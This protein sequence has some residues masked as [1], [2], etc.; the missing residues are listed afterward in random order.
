PPAV[1]RLRQLA[2]P[3]RA[4]PLLPLH[5]GTAS[6]RRGAATGRASRSLRALAARRQLLGARAVGR[7]RVHLPMRGGVPARRRAVA[8]ARARPLAPARRRVARRQDLRQRGLVGPRARHLRA[9]RRR[10]YPRIRR[11]ERR[12]VP[13]RALPDAALRRSAAGHGGLVRALLPRLL[14]LR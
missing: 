14:P 9:R 11:E 10:R 6:V 13:R 1:P 5:A 7:S 8:H 3:R 4:P 12:R 2:E